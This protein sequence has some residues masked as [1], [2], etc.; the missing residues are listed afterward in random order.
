MPTISQLPAPAQS[1]SAAD[2][3]L[4]QQTETGGSTPGAVVVV[5]APVSALLALVPGQGA[6]ATVPLLPTGSAPTTGDSVVM[7]Q[8]GAADQVPYSQFL[9]AQTIDQLQAAGAAADTDT[10]MVG[11]GSNIL[12]RQGFAAI[13]GWLLGHLPTYKMPVLEITANTTLDGSVHN[14][15]ILIV[16]QPVTLNAVP[17]TMGNGF[18]C[19]VL[20][21]GAGSATF[22]AGT[23]TTSGSNT[24]PAG[25]LAQAFALSYS[26]G[27]FVYV[28]VAG[29]SVVL[30]TAPATP[31]GLAAGVPL[32]TSVALSWTA[33]SNALNYIVRYAPSGTTSWTTLAPTSSTNATVTGLNSGA[34]YLFEVSAVNIAGASG[35]SSAVSAT[36]PAVDLPGV[37][38]ALST[39]ATTSTSLPVFWLPPSSG[40]QP[41]SYTVR[42]K[43]SGTGSWQTVSGIAGLTTVLTGLTSNIS[44]DFQ[45][46]AVNAGGISAFT[47]TGTN[48]TLANVSGSSAGWDAIPASLIAGSSG[49]TFSCYTTEGAE[50]ATVAIGISSS[51]TIAPSSIPATGDALA[52]K[53]SWEWVASVSAP[54]MAGTYYAWAI[55]Y[56]GSGAVLWSIVTP[57]IAV[58]S[59]VV[60]PGTPA[61]LVA[62]TSTSSAVP[63]SWTAPSTGGAVATYTLQY[64]LTGGS[65]WTQ[66]TG[67]T[68]TSRTISGLSPSSGYDFQV[69]AMNAGGA[70]VFTSTTTATTA[71]G[72]VS[73]PGT[74]SGLT[75]GTPGSGSSGSVPMSWTA[76]STG[77]AVASYLLQYRLTGGS[78][79]T[80]VSGITGTSATVSGLAASSGYD[81][82]VAAVNTGGTS[83]FTATTTASTTA[84]SGTTAAWGVYQSTM[85]HG[86]GG[87]IF[88]LSISAGTAPAT[89][90]IGISS[91][92]TVPPSPMPAVADGMA[93]NFNGNMWGTYITAPTALGTYYGWAIGYNGSS[94]VIFTIVGASITVT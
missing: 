81:F 73:A 19:F 25:V 93:S 62:G 12:A 91:S 60:A 36:T 50:A 55:G 74:P 57:A 45:V 1:V 52:T 58:T 41:T 77:G 13:W 24:I 30:T 22:S 31:A 7:V 43:I 35:W 44:F 39:G 10:F 2:V 9:N 59:T 76:P 6:A 29:A 16:S 68:G 15:R 3:V 20:P 40:G 79:W 61:S 8:S 92:A 51:A 21:V 85:S 84:S 90:A 87:N 34:T 32:S 38:N 94:A 86:V 4:L 46:A 83:S 65:S 42:Y 63:L 78:S 80:Q 70:S 17:A 71:S 72:S 18:T 47:A 75:A 53:P 27:S 33:S 37:P 66:I 48:H 28:N 56:N 26:G 88:N 49:N 54:A 11:Q 23:I 67:V 69:A 5:R 64:R 14:G 82:Q 89:V